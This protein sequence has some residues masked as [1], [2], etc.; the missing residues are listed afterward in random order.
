MVTPYEFSR[1][2]PAAQKE[3]RI[4]KNIGTQM[5]QIRRII[6]DLLIVYGSVV[7]LGKSQNSTLVTEIMSDI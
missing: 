4:N 2:V 5:T 7:L 1:F 3:S 6:N